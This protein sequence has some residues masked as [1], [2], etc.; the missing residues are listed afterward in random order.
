MTRRRFHPRTYRAILDRQ[1]RKCAGCGAD[2]IQFGVVHFDHIVPVALG[3][4]DE[5]DNLQ[6][7]CI[8]CHK[9]KTTKPIDGDMA[10]IAKAARIREKLSGRRLSKRKREAA[11]I[12]GFE[13]ENRK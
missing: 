10:R 9:A 4:E 7:L 13:T 5:P 12:M 6:A 11:K 8:P 1:D 2:I 3:G